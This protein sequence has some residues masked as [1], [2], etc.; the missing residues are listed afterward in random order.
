MFFKVIYYLIGLVI[1]AY[2][3]YRIS[4][5]NFNSDLFDIWCWHGE[6]KK[7]GNKDVWSDMKEKLGTEIHNKII[8]FTIFTLLEFSWLGVGLLTYNWLLF[9]ALFIYGFLFNRIMKNRMKKYKSV[10]MSST[11]MNLTIGIMVILFAIIN[12]FHL[13]IDLIKLIFGG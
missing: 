9:V 5:K 8:F 4:D 2:K 3:M 13:H 7:K 1:V 6:E 10:F 11:N 12:T